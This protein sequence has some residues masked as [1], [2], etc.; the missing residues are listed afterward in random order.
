MKVERRSE[1][2]TRRQDSPPRP[3]SFDRDINGIT[4]GPQE[5]PDWQ[6]EFFEEEQR[7]AEEAAK[8]AGKAE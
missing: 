4:P 7:A 1:A 5:M 8:A 3:T 6:R 2:K